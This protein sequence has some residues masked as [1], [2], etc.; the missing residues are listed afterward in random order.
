MKQNYYD[1]FAKQG[2]KIIQNRTSLMTAS[3][4]EKTLGIFTTSNMAK[5]LDRNVY[6]QN[7]NQSLSPTGD[8][9]A[10]LDQPG[11]KDMTLKAIDIL[12]A[13]SGKDG[14]FLMYVNTTNNAQD[15]Y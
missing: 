6:K 11:L 14:W 1:E 4:N 15:I 13:R 3:N 8:K 5:W 7:L 12:E 9:K 2:Y 10:A